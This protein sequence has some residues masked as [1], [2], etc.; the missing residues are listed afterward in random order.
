MEQ[1]PISDLIIIVKKRDSIPT[2]KYISHKYPLSLK[3]RTTLVFINRQT[4]NC[5]SSIER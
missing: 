2:E 1:F 4:S 3:N 5:S